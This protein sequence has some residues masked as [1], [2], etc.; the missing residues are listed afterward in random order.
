MPPS[1]S[2]PSKI[3]TGAASGA[4]NFPPPSNATTPPRRAKPWRP[5]PSPVYLHQ[6]RAA[7]DGEIIGAWPDLAPAL[8]ALPKLPKNAVVRTHYHVPLTWAGTGPLRSTR[9]NLT[10]AFFKQA[11]KTFCEV[12]TYTHAIV[13]RALRPRTLDRAI[14]G[15]LQWAAARLGASRPGQGPQPIETRRQISAP[16]QAP[17]Q[18]GFGRRKSD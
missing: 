5:S 10:P 3:S 7:L 4:C 16:R 14:A 6:T 15:E 12:E 17:P 11:R 9:E 8:K 2:A 13:P 18:V 1:N